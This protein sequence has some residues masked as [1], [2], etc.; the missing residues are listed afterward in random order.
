MSDFLE[1]LYKESLA[2]STIDNIE[3]LIESGKRLD[4]IPVQPLYF[5]FKKL[6]LDQ[7][8][9]YLDK[10]S[11]EQRKVMLDIDLWE[12]DV[13]DVN[14]F[15]DWFLVYAHCPNEKIRHEFIKSEE[16]LLFLKGR[17]AIHTFDVEDPVYP[18]HDNYFLTDD[19]QLLIEFDE[20]FTGVNELKLLIGEL[21]DIM[22]VEGAYTYL[23]KMISDSF[24][25][26]MEQQYQQK[27]KELEDYGIIDYYKALEMLADFPSRMHID[28]FIKKKEPMNFVLDVLQENQTVAAQFLVKLKDIVDDNFRIEFE[29]LTD[30]KDLKW[31]RFN[32]VRLI[33]AKMVYEGDLK[34]IGHVGIL[35]ASKD[36]SAGLKLG[37]EYIRAHFKTEHSLFKYFSFVDIFRIGNSLVQLLKREIEKEIRKYPQGMSNFWGGL[38]NN[39]FENLLER[40][41]KVGRLNQKAEVVDTLLRLSE[42][43][44]VVVMNKELLPV[45]YQF[46]QVVEQL[47]D[48]GS[49]SENYYLN[50]SL[51]DL[52]FEAVIISTFINFT[53]GAFSQDRNV[54]KLGV[55][56]KEFKQF[57]ISLFAEC[58]FKEDDL[59]KLDHQIALFSEQFGLNQ[60]QYFNSYLK[61]VI[62]EN[63]AGYDYAH[64]SYDDYKHVGGVIFFSEV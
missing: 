62:I 46:Y 42:L 29:K 56:V 25:I 48:S 18:D 14:T 40:P 6:P 59:H 47:K 16:F 10:L 24:L 37:L 4:V 53:L 35:K 64:L 15:Y 22:G 60:L 36:V 52:D 34:E 38:L 30:E 50:Y 27:V 11:P 57:L 26:T 33:N 39:H 45:V 43:E 8:S 58:S 54:K 23:F 12:K 32:F 2:Y 61:D 5:A 13:L 49:I 31:L 7:V 55:R 20:N 17:F 1:R 21:Y 9:L 63:L 19:N 28:L 51:E 44:Q 3:S 41:V